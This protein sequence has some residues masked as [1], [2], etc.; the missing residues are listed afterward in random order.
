M[1]C[2]YTLSK[3]SHLK[4]PSCRQLYYHN[5]FIL[6]PQKNFFRPNLTSFYVTIQATFPPPKCSIPR[7]QVHFWEICGIFFFLID[8]KPWKPLLTDSLLIFLFLFFCFDLKFEKKKQK[9]KQKKHQ[10]L[11]NFLIRW[12]L[13]H[14]MAVQIHFDK[15]TID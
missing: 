7:S 9:K 1:L 4:I 10:T 14:T 8:F 15:F 3:H 13:Q 6:S 5:V 11:E 2:V 12:G